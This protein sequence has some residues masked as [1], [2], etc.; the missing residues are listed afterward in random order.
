[1]DEYGTAASPSEPKSIGSFFGLP[2]LSFAR[3][4]QPDGPFAFFVT[5]HKKHVI[6]SGVFMGEQ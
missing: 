5:L 1:I 2:Q 6:F 4:F 3:T